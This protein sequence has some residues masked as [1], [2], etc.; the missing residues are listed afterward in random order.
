MAKLSSRKCRSH[1]NRAVVSLAALLLLVGVASLLSGTSIRDETGGW[2]VENTVSNAFIFNDF[3]SSFSSKDHLQGDHLFQQAR[4]GEVL[5]PFRFHVYPSEPAFSSEVAEKNPEFFEKYSVQKSY[6][7]EWAVANT[8]RNHPLH[9]DDPEEAEIFIVPLME[10]FWRFSGRKGH[11]DAR[12]AFDQTMESPKKYGDYWKRYNGHDHYAMNVWYRNLN[13]FIP[14]IKSLTTQIKTA[15]SPECCIRW[16][17]HEHFRRLSKHIVVPEFVTRSDRKDIKVHDR[18]YFVM[19]VGSTG[20]NSHKGS[21]V[22][23][24]IKQNMDDANRDDVKFMQ[25]K[26]RNELTEFQYTIEDYMAKST[27]CPHSPGDVDIAARPYT[28]IANGC[29]PVMFCD[30]CSYAFENFVDYSK[31][32]YFFPEGYLY[33]TSWNFVRELEKIPVEEI[34]EKQRNLQNALKFFE[35]DDD[36]TKGALNTIVRQLELDADELRRF[37]RWFRWRNDYPHLDNRTGYKDN[38]FNDW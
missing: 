19:F 12:K 25:L 2:N 30:W 4:V 22:R 32:A 21:R 7:H 15:G 1:G 6:H 18:E 16:E 10:S 8:L 11:V 38:H 34:R 27:F 36:P 28:A 35:W 9:T 13:K 37:R 24:L 26:K 33:N 3:L 29:I 23:G 5:R 31:I 17:F 20:V 14:N